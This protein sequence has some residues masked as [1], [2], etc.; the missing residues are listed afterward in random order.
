MKLLILITIIVFSQS[1]L[2]EESSES[3]QLVEMMVT[4]KA[5]GMCGVFSQMARFQESTKMPGGDE[6]I[7]RFLNTEAAR[8]GY[9]L[10]EFMAACPTVTKNY[11]AYMNLLNNEG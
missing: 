5:T 8:L 1:L 3:T 10:E 2:A 7:V 6:F 9:S 4:A 11:N